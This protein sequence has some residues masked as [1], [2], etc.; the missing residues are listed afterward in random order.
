MENSLTFSELEK[1]WTL[2]YDTFILMIDFIISYVWFQFSLIIIRHCI[3]KEKNNNN[4][5]YVY[6]Y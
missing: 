3:S 6:M 2:E 4:N 5:C 1:G